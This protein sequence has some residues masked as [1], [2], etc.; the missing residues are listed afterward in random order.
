M[1]Q[2][3]RTGPGA[4]ASA[5]PEAIPRGVPRAVL[6]E[7]LDRARRAP[8]GVNTQPWQVAVLQGASR[9]A[10]VAV[11][12]AALPPLLA[13]APQ[14]AR[15]WDR[16][17]L[18]PGSNAWP[19]PARE[20]SGT[21]F[22]A[23]A[24]AAFGAGALAGEADLADYF[25]LHGAPVALVCTLDRALGLGSVL[26]CGMFLQNIALLASARGLR[27]QVQPGWKGLADEV[28]ALLRAPDSAVLLAVVA[29]G[30][31]GQADALASAPAP[32]ADDF[33]RWLD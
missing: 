27:A 33:V 20:Q 10:L 1:S 9:D 17:R 21:G 26:D 30:Y 8:S 4:G 6:E 18:Q 14:Q 11:G 12:Q 25:G 24:D 22:L 19:G 23:C 13:G 28:L 15:F 2:A 29:L 5:A 16:F 31:G 32:Q 3:G 7:I